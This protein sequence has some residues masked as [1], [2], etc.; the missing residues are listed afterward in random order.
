M[1][2]ATSSSTI[3]EEPPSASTPKLHLHYVTVSGD[4]TPRRP[5]LIN[6][7]LDLSTKARLGGRRGIKRKALLYAGPDIDDV[8]QDIT[9]FLHFFP[10]ICSKQVVGQLVRAAKIVTRINLGKTH[11]ENKIALELLINSCGLTMATVNKKQYL[12]MNNRFI[13]G[14][15]KHNHHIFFNF[16]FLHVSKNFD[17]GTEIS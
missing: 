12:V 5:N 17:F 8:E 14:T 6:N 16:C 9:T 1:P 2:T 10:T 7:L 15:I 4:S 11:S 13:E 3:P